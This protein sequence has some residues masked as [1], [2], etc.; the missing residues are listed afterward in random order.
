MPGIHKL[1]GKRSI[2]KGR[3]ERVRGGRIRGTV[4]A[5]CVLA[6]VEARGWEVR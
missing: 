4:V 6:D 2:G 3:R 1:R 5:V